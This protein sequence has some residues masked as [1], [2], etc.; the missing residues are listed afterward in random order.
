M[1]ELPVEITFSTD[2]HFPTNNNFKPIQ[3]QK[4]TVIRFRGHHSWPIFK[5]IG[6]ET[7]MGW[8]SINRLGPPPGPDVPSPTPARD[9][10]L[11]GRPR[12]VIATV[13]GGAEVT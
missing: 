3:G 8:G 9:Q 7:G 4:Y 13:S 6:A 2:R 12:V 11:I 5:Q 10:V 1:K